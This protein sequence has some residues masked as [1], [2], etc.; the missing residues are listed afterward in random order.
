MPAIVECS[1]CA[2]NNS[3]TLSGVSF[4]SV[5][6]ERIVPIEMVTRTASGAISHP[7][8][9][10][11][12][13][14]TLYPFPVAIGAYA[15]QI[16]I[17]DGLPVPA[18]DNQR[19]RRQDLAMGKLLSWIDHNGNPDG[20]VVALSHGQDLGLTMTTIVCCDTH[21]GIDTVAQTDDGRP[22]TSVSHE[23]GH[24]VGL[25]H[26]GYNCPQNPAGSGGA[27][28]WPPPDMGDLNGFGIDPRTGSGGSAG[29]FRILGTFDS[30][31][32]P[33]QNFDVMSYCASTDE[34]NS[35]ISVTN[36]TNL[37]NNHATG[38]RRAVTRAALPNG[39]AAGPGAVIGGKLG[40]VAD[41][42]PALKVTAMIP[43]NGPAQMLDVEP[44]TGRTMKPAPASPVTI[45]VLDAAGNV[46]S[47]TKVPVTI[48]HMDG[49]G[50]F[51]LVD[52]VVRA[53]RGSQV[54]VAYN[55]K[56]LVRRTKPRH[57][58]RVTVVAPSAGP[59]SAAGARRSCTGRSAT[60]TGS[61]SRSRSSTR[62]TGGAGA[63]WLPACAA[64]ATGSRW[65]C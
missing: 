19:Q 54:A 53:P 18:G 48:G 44:V 25:Q 7:S 60:P 50:A 40:S 47:S 55:G 11:N 1:G 13:A 63:R 38:A 39:G 65:N 57:R 15:G 12:D 32:A 17:S 24:E 27:T 9:V 51:L 45:K 41:P 23:F 35:W 62:P 36:W 64:R 14:Q 37:V 58:P 16:D 3:I 31:A 30:S 2:D 59:A 29:P 10:Y 56:T 43:G 26:A 20:H 28:H 21:L 42:G 46:A 6:G 8:P 61:S 22:L 5:R 52:G 49:N 4:R 33:V 34:S